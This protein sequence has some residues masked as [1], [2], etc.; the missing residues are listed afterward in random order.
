MEATVITPNN[1]ETSESI[2]GNTVL[3]QESVAL[4]SEIND[5]NEPSVSA[6]SSD[7]DSTENSSHEHVLP[8]SDRDKGKVQ[9]NGNSDPSQLA[10][11]S[12]SN[13][14]A[15]SKPYYTDPLTK[16]NFTREYIISELKKLLQS[17]DRGPPFTIQRFAELLLRPNA[18]YPRNQEPKYL[19]ALTRVLNVESCT[20]DFEQIDLV[21]L[22]E[23]RELEHME[24][25]AQEEQDDDETDF[26][27][28]II[29]AAAAA[30]ES[31]AKASGSGTVT[32]I[33][34]SSP[35]T[36]LSNSASTDDKIK[37]DSSEE[38]E[39]TSEEFSTPHHNMIATN[40]TNG[41]EPSTPSTPSSS[42]KL[43][44]EH[45]N[46][47][48]VMSPIPWI[49]E[50]SLKSYMDDLGE[51]DEDLLEEEMFSHEE[52]EQHREEDS[53]LKEKMSY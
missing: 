5:A 14:T 10:D 15:T 29:T 2:N 53:H 3:D 42:S 7:Q 22:S 41:A 9:R 26:P 35:G 24:R 30:A 33:L 28:P 43:P 17:H 27:F 40:F 36:Q 38:V 49:T 37:D 31:A 16:D 32:A 45:L 12:K 11:G 47:V 25:E 34:P 4:S 13:L 19:M 52:I 1:A 21:A 39:N 18:Q 8:N 51:G 23:E 20:R 44:L 50:S 46:S 6:T 48:V